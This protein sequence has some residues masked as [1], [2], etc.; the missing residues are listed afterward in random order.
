MITFTPFDQ[1]SAISNQQSAIK[2]FQKPILL[3]II[4]LLIH[5][6]AVSQ[7]GNNC[8]T[9]IVV[10]RIPIVFIDQISQDIWITFKAKSDS[11]KI[12]YQRDLTENP[13]SIFLYSGN[14]DSLIFERS[15]SFTSASEQQFSILC[16]TGENYRLKLTRNCN[17]CSLS[18]YQITLLHGVDENANNSQC[19][20]QIPSS[21]YND[22][23]LVCNPSLEY[24]SSLPTNEGQ[25]HRARNW[26][27]LF[28][29][30]VLRTPDYF[31]EDFVGPTPIN[32][33]FFYMDIPYN[34][35]GITNAP[36]HPNGNKAYCGIITEG[37]RQNQPGTPKYVEYIQGKL[38][39]PLVP[40]QT[41][42]FQVLIS[43]ACISEMKSSNI[44][45]VFS[46]GLLQS[47]A[48]SSLVTLPTNPDKITINGF[49]QPQFNFQLSNVVG[50]WQLLSGTFTPNQA[51]THFTIGCFDF[52]NN[53]STYTLATSPPISSC[54]PGPF[55]PFI[56]AD[57]IGQNTS[58]SA[59]WAYYFLDNFSIQTSD[60]A[61]NEILT[62]CD[63]NTILSLNAPSELNNVFWYD[64]NGLLINSNP[65]NTITL[66][67]NNWSVGVYTYTGY[68]QNGCL[69]NGTITVYYSETNCC[70]AE[71]NNNILLSLQGNSNS[72]FLASSI[73]NN[74]NSST[75]A[76]V[77]NLN[78]VIIDGHLIIDQNLTFTNAIDVKLYPGSKISIQNGRTLTVSN[79]AV[80]RACTTMWDGIYLTG[81]TPDNPVPEIVVFNGA[82]IQDMLN[83][84][85]AKNGGLVKIGDNQA[86]VRFNKN[87]RNITIQQYH[88][89]STFF[90]YYLGYI[91]NCE[92]TCKPTALT[93]NTPNLIWPKLGEKP[94]F[95]I[96]IDDVIKIKIGQET[97]GMRTYF[98]TLNRGIIS[99]SSDLIVYNCDFTDIEA[100][101]YTAEGINCDDCACPGGTAICASGK[102]GNEEGSIAANSV[103]IGDLMLKKNYFYRCIN[104]IYLTK[105]IGGSIKENELS[106][107]KKYGI[108]ARGFSNLPPNLYNNAP[109]LVVNK[110]DFHRVGLVNIAVVDYRMIPKWITDN[111]I[112]I[113]GINHPTVSGVYVAN[114]IPTI[115]P[116]NY[117]FIQDNNIHSVQI[118]IQTDN[119]RSPIIYSNNIYLRTLNY[120][121]DVDRSFGIKVTKC[122]YSHIE[123][124]FVEADN[125]ENWWTIGIQAEASHRS[126]INCNH[127]LR[128]GHG[129]VWSGSYSKPRITHNKMQRNAAGFTLNW[130]TIGI[131][132]QQN[133]QPH[134]ADNIWVGPYD[135]YYHTKT[136]LPLFPNAPL[137]GTMYA[138]PL[139]GTAYLPQPFYSFAP[140]WG[141]ELSPDFS[142]ANFGTINWSDHLNF[143]N[144]CSH[145][146]SDTTDHRGDERRDSVYTYNPTDSLSEAW[147]SHWWETLRRYELVYSDSQ[148]TQA[149]QNWLD[150]LNG[151]ALARLFN[152]NELAAIP[153]KLV[154]DYDDL[155]SENQS[156]PENT[157]QE[158]IW[159]QA[160]SLWFTYL[161]WKID[162]DT[163]I[164]LNQIID[165]ETV[166]EIAWLCPL[167]YGPGVV[168]MRV[169]ANLLDTTY[170]HY[171]NACEGLSDPNRSMNGMILASGKSDEDESHDFDFMINSPIITANI[172]PLKVYPNPAE[173]FCL[174]ESSV[175]LLDNAQIR[176]INSMGQ[177]VKCQYKRL[178]S[179]SFRL[180]LADIINGV[181]LI[182]LLNNHQ[183]IDSGKL[184][185]WHP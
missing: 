119:V 184:T 45:V 185:V 87:F 2:I 115:E 181:Y 178:N 180:E 35:Y 50:Q 110:N 96:K 130:A 79:F 20:P 6:I 52:W 60:N 41:Y 158:M 95:G 144:E 19:D 73:I 32:P 138:R 29:P 142:G 159:K 113:P 39:S 127:L 129:I 27:N 126:L 62:L 156:I 17:N 63:L 42:R 162:S 146:F 37:G 75:I 94:D 101:H 93:D 137:L 65:S 175:E 114:N 131:Q 4:L 91:R 135:G 170:V 55:N 134:Y 3:K 182:Q 77:G 139:P 122:D 49:N 148:R 117:T 108:R 14:C 173:S 177:F 136:Y 15:F 82:T 53:Q 70:S 102:S 7:P 83:G 72:V 109:S 147:N 40:N 174:I 10:N 67:A 64:P 5:S 100:Y 103:I 24:Y 30:S 86:R 152:L 163:I 92:F 12:V 151:G 81:S 51:F 1:Q 98:E 22:C 168:N 154:I 78:T 38:K 56:N 165:I 33:F 133:N 25:L 105:N 13:D 44:Q 74:L 125:R 71:N 112:N 66:G 84:V 128:T 111:D 179:N 23:E 58:T 8:Q 171:I 116:D 16:T 155:L 141:Q 61:T 26:N 80:L 36:F 90:N 167:N 183:I 143:L 48:N 76:P 34:S 160:N 47:S 97:S 21:I 120:N 57:Q 54:T 132:F 59:S 145:E 157:Y 43:M 121:S 161:K 172:S 88:P 89:S 85:V 69:R 46:N 99:G 166:K 9:P 18:A 31:H 11:V 104:G 140:L 123:L 150:S 169:L 164:S 153:Y 106:Q 107:I 124:N 176:L 28:Y 118:G 149:E 68:D